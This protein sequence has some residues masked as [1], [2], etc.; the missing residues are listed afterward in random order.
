M[1]RK[2]NQRDEGNNTNSSTL[3]NCNRV[4]KRNKNIG[5]AGYIKTQK[6]QMQAQETIQE[7]EGRILGVSDK[8]EEIESMTKENLK[9]N[10]SLTKKH[11]GNVGHSEKTKP[12]N[13]RHRRRQ[14]MPPQWCRKL[15]QK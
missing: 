8:L 10:K 7:I 6:L 9:Q 13:K 14:R 2:N 15:T 11:P 12:R 1:S 4:N 5:N 3:E